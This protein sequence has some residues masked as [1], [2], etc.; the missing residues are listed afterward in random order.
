MHRCSFACII[1]AFIIATAAF[2][3]QEEKAAPREAE[4]LETEKK[5]E[6]SPKD[7]GGQDKKEAAS[8]D[9]AKKSTLP[10]IIITATK[11]GIKKRET[12]SS[13]TII[14]AA[15][16]EQ[17]QKRFVADILKIEPGLS[18][19]TSSTLGGVSELYIRGTAP[20]HAV[21]LIDG[22]KVN[23][24]TAPGNGFDF[25]NL[26]TDNIERIEIVRGSQSTLYGS[27]AIGGVVNIITK[28]G[29]GPPR[30]SVSAEGGSYVTF[31]ETA[32]VS[33][34]SDEVEYSA[35]VSR[36]DS[37]GYNR[38]A[39]WRG[40][41]K[42]YVTRDNDGYHS[43]V[44]SSRLAVKTI[45]DSRLSLSFRYNDSEAKIDDGAFDDDKNA[46]Q[47]DQSFSGIG[48]FQIPL[49]T[50]WEMN[51]S[52]S[53]LT[54]LTRFKDLPDQYDW[55]WE[56]G[57]GPYDTSNMWY[58]GKRVGAELR[59]RFSIK[60][61]DEIT[62]GVSYDKE[63]ADTMPYF[64]GWPPNEWN[65]MR[66]DSAIDRSEGT[67]AAYAQNHLKIMKRIYVITGLRY[68]KPS[69]FDPRLDYSISG[70]FILPWSE[71]RL[72]SSLGTGY[73]V[74]SLY[75][76]YSTFERYD[77]L[78]PYYLRPEKTLSWDAGVEQ[79]LWK[80]R[81][82]L[83][84]NYYSIAYRNMI[85]YDTILDSWGRY[86]NINAITR[87]VECIA[88]LKPVEGLS[89]SGHYTYTQSNNKTFHSGE[90]IRRPKHRAGFSINYAFLSRGNVN[91]G[92]TYCGRQKDYW[93]YPYTSYM[94]PWFKFDLAVSWWIIEQLQ[95]FFRAEN[96][97]NENYEEVRGYRMPRASFYGGLK[98]VF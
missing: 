60:D 93:K 90:M 36:L 43:T 86:Y 38:S 9:D 72:K 18:V 47:K 61:I 12:G 28:R 13:V 41:R 97:T 22:V 71:T 75:Q 35:A 58:R 40:I 10:E 5:E 96:F 32:A 1:I 7:A 20:A 2:A 66:P 78:T 59:N 56:W 33:G 54:Q 91:L 25:A 89:L 8:K 83:E 65:T 70:S 49:F 67:W 17:K 42:S 6:Q 53:Y 63:Y 30:V 82:V 27:D 68:T 77:R 15:E 11:S 55:D 19:T 62:I 14:N 29:F 31:R 73:K 88:T 94:S 95:A 44:A 74:P 37:R 39:S 69:R 87:G 16:I 51:L 45:R 81:V 3:Q 57:T 64:G 26:T 24:P 92:F 85:Y 34:G 52:A 79:P 98:A 23:N 80:D 76:R 21:V 50:W 48:S 4:K 46:S 84:V